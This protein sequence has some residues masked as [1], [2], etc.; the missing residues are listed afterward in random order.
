M[1][2]CSS[3]INSRYP[4]ICSH[5]RSLHSQG[6]LN[7]SKW[8]LSAFGLN[9]LQ[10]ALIL[11]L[12]GQFAFMPISIGS[13]PFDCLAFYGGCVAKRNNLLRDGEG[14]LPH[15]MSK[16]R[17]AAHNYPS[18][19]RPTNTM[20]CNYGTGCSSTACTLPPFSLSS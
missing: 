10:I 6:C 3:S 4:L 13:L 7:F 8:L 1:T 5:S 11:A 17:C 15:F 2:P 18:R 19:V 16:H 9:L 14:G 20:F 12:G